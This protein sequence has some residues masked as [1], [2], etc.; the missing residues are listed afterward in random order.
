M[1][2]N[3]VTWWEMASKDAAKTV[4]FF[5]RVFSWELK[6]EAGLGGYHQMLAP[7][8]ENGFYGGGIYQVEEGQEPSMIIYLR[9]DD[10]D[11][12]AREVEEHGG[13][14]VTPPFDVPGLGRLCIFTDPSGQ[15]F[16]MIRRVWE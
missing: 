7:G 9:V 2:A 11:A 4:E 10:V 14:V 12:K 13:A 1:D 6:A 3:P 15:K 5:N 8:H 16:A